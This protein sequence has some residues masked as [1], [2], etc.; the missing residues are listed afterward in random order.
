MRCHE[1]P[2]VQEYASVEAPEA[3]HAKQALRQLEFE[4]LRVT[5]Q[6]RC[7]AEEDDVAEQSEPSEQVLRFPAAGLVQLTD[8]YRIGHGVTDLGNIQVVNRPSGGG[9]VPPA[10]LK[11]V[12]DVA[13]LCR[14]RQLPVAVYSQ[15]AAESDVLHARENLQCPPRGRCPRRDGPGGG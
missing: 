15:S 4:T 14:L 8:W 10:M 3:S 12:R 5:G 6:H 2:V 7:R 11:E 1:L 9:L 13:G